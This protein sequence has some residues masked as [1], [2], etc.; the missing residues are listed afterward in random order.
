LHAV[1]GL[2]M[3]RHVLNACAELLPERIIAVIAPGM[4]AVEKV[5][6]RAAALFNR[7]RWVPVMPRKR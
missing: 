4:D 1:A 6:A 5:L 2:P 3:I 7:S